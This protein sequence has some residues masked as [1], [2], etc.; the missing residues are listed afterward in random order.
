MAVELSVVIPIHNEESIVF[1]S[2]AGLLERLPRISDS[3]E[4]IL[5]ENGSTDDT[6]AVVRDLQ[7][8][9]EEV[10]Y[11]HVEEPN[12]GRALKEGILGAQG[13]YVVCDEIDRCD[14]D[15]Y[16]SSMGLLREKKAEMVVGSK[17]AP[18]AQ[19]L[20]PW[21]RNLASR[22]FSGLLK[23]GAGFQGTDTHGLKAFIREPLLDVVNACKVEGNL[24]ASELVIRAERA[25]RRI[26]E[27]PL[28]V[29]EKRRP[30][31][32]LVRRVPRAI[33]N[34]GRL[35]WIIRMQDRDP[36]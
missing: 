31:I 14:I 15:F 26:V 9:Y 13:K 18:G 22:V 2:V 34:L 6:L 23:I 28:T 33:Y 7:Q 30:T 17:L 3:F 8:R 16:R 1:D 27:L 20:R 12:Y 24:F 11:L 29:R 32:N 19:D 10:G 35:A 5:A 25:G 21:V 36:K 4:L